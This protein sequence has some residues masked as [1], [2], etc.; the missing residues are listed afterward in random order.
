MLWVLRTQQEGSV[1]SC[2]HMTQSHPR[3]AIATKA[4]GCRPG[5]SLDSLQA[6]G[7]AIGDW[8]LDTEGNRTP[9]RRHSGSHLI[10]ASAASPSRYSSHVYSTVLASESSFSLLSL[11]S[12]Y[13]AIHS[14]SNTLRSLPVP[15]R[16][17]R[18]IDPIRHRMPDDFSNILN[19]KP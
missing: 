16:H 10:K 6:Q 3:G 13:S 11:V 7:G 12:S 18:A 19:A 14:A 17:T 1:P 2:T 4:T 15:C 9:T 8:L 5:V